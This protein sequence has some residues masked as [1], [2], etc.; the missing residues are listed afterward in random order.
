MYLNI[1]LKNNRGSW[2]PLAST[3]SSQAT[4]STQPSVPCSGMGCWMCPKACMVARAGSWSQGR[5]P[6]YMPHQQTFPSFSFQ[7][8]SEWLNTDR[9]LGFSVC[10]FSCLQHISSLSLYHSRFLFPHTMVH[11][12][13]TC[14]GNGLL[15]CL[16]QS[17][18]SVIHSKGSKGHS[19]L[20]A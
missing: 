9:G 19:G 10:S 2:L 3:S 20:F 13:P 16:I 12:L 7:F 5:D 6:K 8:L 17:S 15:F 11:C 1:Y 14:C 4:P 18:I